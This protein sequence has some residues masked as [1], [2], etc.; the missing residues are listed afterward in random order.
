MTEVVS[1]K[2][3]AQSIFD[4]LSGVISNYVD[5]ASEYIDAI[6]KR[7]EI[8]AELQDMG[9]SPRFLNMLEQVGRKT[10][11]PSL[12]LDGCVSAQY[13]RKLPYSD[14]SKIIQNGV[15]VMEWNEKDH[16]LIPYLDL[17]R[18]QCQIVFCGS[19][20]RSLAEQRTV[21]EDMKS[22]ELEPKSE[23]NAVVKGD[24]VHISKP[25]IYSRD[26]LLVWLGR[27]K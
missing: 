1:I 11:V 24:R 27:M 22:C 15:T 2:A 23:P 18:R 8:K 5:I 13:L 12:L 19:R 16:R 14:Q 26:E 4:R 25:G 9:L 3:A 10:L 6:D 21:I 7:P 17:T 20:V